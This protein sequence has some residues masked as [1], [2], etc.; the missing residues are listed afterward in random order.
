MNFKIEPNKCCGCGAC[1]IIC[2]KDAIHL[3]KDEYGFEIA[4]IDSEKCVKCGACKKV[5]PFENVSGKK[6]VVHAY[7]SSGKNEKI[8]A[9]CSSGGIFYII[10]NRIL[11]NGGVVCGTVLDNDFNAMVVSTDNHSDLER[12]LGSK[13]VQS[14]M[15]GVY[16]EIKINLKAG[17]KV[18]F[19]G[20]PCQVAALHNMFSDNENLILID[21]VCHGTPNNSLFRDYIKLLERKKK[22]KITKFVF[23]DKRYGQ[24]TKGSYTT[25]NGR[26][27]PIHS[28]DSSYYS[29]FLKGLLFRDSCYNCPYAT[30]NRVGDISICD[31][32]GVDIEEPEVYTFLK[33]QNVKAISGVVV[34]SEQGKRTLNSVANELYIKPV[35]YNSIKKNNPQL[36]MPFNLD[37]NSRTEVLN[38]YLNGG[39]DAV[40]RYYYKKY[41]V[42]IIISKLSRLFPKKLVKKIVDWRDRVK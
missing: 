7:A 4:K 12:M 26:L 15:N 31:F 5:C 1:E 27:C 6:Q 28:K 38:L 10:A 18:L 25:I 29:L 39:F 11:E 3:E 37:E 14:T 8:I 9:N 17:K 32:W 22:T 30:E 34:N 33:D 36:N 42:S 19:C 16:S 35:K 20:T 13:Y 24:D 21:I 2:T 23:R 40:D 41:G